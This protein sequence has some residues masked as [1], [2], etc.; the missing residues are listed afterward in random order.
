[1]RKPKK[2]TKEFNKRSNTIK[3]LKTKLTRKC[4]RLWTKRPDK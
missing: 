2:K 3:I 4:L 1:M